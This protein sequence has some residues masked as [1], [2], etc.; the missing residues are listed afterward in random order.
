MSVRTQCSWPLPGTRPCL[1]PLLGTTPCPC[2]CGP[3]RQSPCRHGRGSN[4]KRA[5]CYDSTWQH[6][7]WAEPSGRVH[8]C[9]DSTWQHAAWA[10][11][12]GRVQ[13]YGHSGRSETIVGV[14][15]R[16]KCWGREGHR[17]RAGRMDACR[18]LGKPKAERI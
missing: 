18:N 10:E 13:Y 17:L 16:A 12:S 3:A 2:S 1:W 6:T 11:L 9:C 4:D 14:W 5:T 15:T 8:T 7:A